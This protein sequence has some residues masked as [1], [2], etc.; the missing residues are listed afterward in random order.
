VTLGPSGSKWFGLLPGGRLA[1]A[2]V[3][4]HAHG[5]RAERSLAGYFERAAQEAE[6]A[7][8]T[9]MVRTSG[10][11]A[12]PGGGEGS[13]GRGAGAGDRAR[14]QV[15]IDDAL[16]QVVAPSRE[17][18]PAP[19]R[20]L[21]DRLGALCA[22]APRISA[23]GAVA[24]VPLD[25]RINPRESWADRLRGRGIA[26]S[27]LSPES[28]ASGSAALRTALAYPGILAPLD[29]AG[30]AAIRRLPGRQES[31]WFVRTAAGHFR[32]DLLFPE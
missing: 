17:A 26:F 31:G 10:L 9:T 3:D 6:L 12:L 21:V 29:E 15:W 27:T 5:E 23:V 20:A 14:V 8:L 2:T 19:L 16:H 30:L 22:T 24:A 13:E 11:L 7:E 32:I 1:S 25:E 28:L 18:A 4:E